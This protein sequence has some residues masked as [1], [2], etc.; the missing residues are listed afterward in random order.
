MQN[1]CNTLQTIL[2]MYRKQNIEKLNLNKLDVPRPIKMYMY[3][4]LILLRVH[5]AFYLMLI[6]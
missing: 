2:Y 4:K 5:N 1:A 3:N 6:F